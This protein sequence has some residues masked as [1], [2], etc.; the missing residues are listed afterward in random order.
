[1]KDATYKEHGSAMSCVALH[2]TA[3]VILKRRIWLMTSGCH[4][5][6]RLQDP[7]NQNKVMLCN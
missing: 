5:R 6:R 4:S 1:M 3:L 2:C 7:L